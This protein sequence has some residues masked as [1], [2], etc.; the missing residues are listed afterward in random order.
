MIAHTDRAGAAEDAG[1]VGDAEVIRRSLEEPEAF[2]LLFD[3]YAPEIHRYA[4]RRLGD[5]LADD[6]VADT[7]LAA[8]RRRDRY[9]LTRPDARPWLYGIAGNLIGRHRRVEIRS[10]R[11][12]ARTGVDEVAESY[13]DR[14]DARVSASAVQEDL[15]GALAGL[16]AGDREVLLLVAWADL[17]YDEVAEAV[18][19]P[20]GTVRS[21]LHRAR[22]KSR[23]ALGGADPTAIEE[24]RHG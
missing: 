14:V 10:Y 4:V 24:E 9:D 23:A 12:L 15:A 22:R 19:I 17:T 20:V 2:A 1:D 18:G 16:S 11:A 5:S 3:R 8:F 6:V 21:R 13:A 7:F